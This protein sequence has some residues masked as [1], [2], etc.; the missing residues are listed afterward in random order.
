M[1]TSD[2]TGAFVW[3]WLPGATQPVVAGRLDSTADKRL[4]F[5][6]GRSYLAR[7]D[8]IPIYLP[9]LPLRAGIQEPVG[10]LAMP[11]CIRDASPD[12]WGRRVILNRLAAR[13]D[14]SIGELIFLLESG[15]DR[16]GALDFQASAT[17]YV[18]RDPRSSTLEELLQAA[19]R[20]QAGEPLT[21]AMEAALLYGTSIGGARPKALIQDR[22]TKLIAKF[23]TSTD[24]YGVVQAEFVAMRL[25][26]LAGL[27]VAPVRL[28]HAMGRPVLLVER[29][30]RANVPGG[31]RRR[32]MVSAL[33]ILG[34]DEMEARYASY[35]DLAERIRLRFTQPKR[36]L[37]E[38]FGR[39]VF[40][41][42]CGNTDDHAR[43][44]AAFW[45]GRMLTL[46]P[47]YDI[48]PQMRTGREASQAMLIAAE[49]RASRVSSCL[50]A[51]R[52]FGL[53]AKAAADMIAIQ[54]ET[55]ARHWRAVCDEAGMTAVDRQ[56]LMGRQFLNRFAFDDLDGPHDRLRRL[57]DEARAA[58]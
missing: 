23:G 18:A 31:W 21:P 32:A 57:A 33:T 19:D 37:A 17:E 11:S 29:F 28:T 15:S 20:V 54:I 40:N 10:I 14:A 4:R 45:D 44:H 48:C 36:T 9:E 39:I 12:A 22:A 1:T 2:A 58:A 8:A 38:L 6:Y 35:A 46:T 52:V 42:L 24:T 43:N 27:D 30:D 53:S 5:T 7:D 13:D 49:D 25:A 34:L 55:V 26:H 51:A 47:A 16:P 56:L 41:I 3:I 50:A